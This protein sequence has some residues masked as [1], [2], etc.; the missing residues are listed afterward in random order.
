MAAAGGKAK[1]WRVDGIST[2]AAFMLAV[3]ETG[4]DLSQIAHDLDFAGFPSFP[5]PIEKSFIQE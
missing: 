4:F 3:L 5:A 1:P 2:R